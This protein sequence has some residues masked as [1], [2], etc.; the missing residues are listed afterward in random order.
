M[1]N[2]KSV[3]A[4]NKQDPDAIVCPDAFRNN[5]RITREDFESEEDFQK[6]KSW[7]DE[8]Y[9][10]ADNADC[11]YHKKTLSLDALSA[12][13]VA[14]ESTEVTVIRRMDAES[15]SLLS[16]LLVTNL[17]GQL[18]ETQCRR[19][20]LVVIEG[21]STYAIA[22]QEGVTHQSVRKSVEAAKE[23]LKKFLLK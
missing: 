3:Y 2:T 6:F 20:R 22:R 8:D 1:L 16:Q 13:V 10:K 14:V 17:E 7:S 19:L 11:D 4:L 21:I 23:N 5:H 18:T 9:R 15:R 12:K